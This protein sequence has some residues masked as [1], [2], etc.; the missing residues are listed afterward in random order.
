MEYKSHIV[1]RDHQRA[2][3]IG[4]VTWLGFWV[5]LVLS[6]FKILAGY[7]GNSRAVVADG[8][9][10]LS[11]LITD[12]AVLVGVR[13]WMAPPDNVHRYGYKRLESLISLLIGIVLG[14]AGI[15]IAYDAV[16]RI[17]KQGDER[18]GS[19]LALFAAFSSVI[20][21]EALYRWTIK[22]AR[23]LKSDAVE[24]N[25][26]DHR[27]DALSSIPIVATV[28]IAMWFPSLAIVD[29]LGAVLVAGFILYAAG[30]ICISA[31]HVLVDGGTEPEV[32]AKIAAFCLRTDGVKG[33]HDLR[34]RFVGQ[35]LQLD[36]HVSVDAGLT[37]REGNHIAHALEDSLYSADAAECIGVEIFDV[38]IHIDPWHPDEPESIR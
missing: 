20:I 15:G 8:V 9:H 21:K 30:K 37:I 13:F 31:T 26:W 27:S 17:G 2:G 36:L 23:E 32:Y 29:L 22:K 5:N 16:S 25:A 33:V 3:E 34:A 12:I 14:L 24:A 7:L 38:L 4:R 28:A 19:L 6:A 11:D 10:S 35:G 18:V 1:Q